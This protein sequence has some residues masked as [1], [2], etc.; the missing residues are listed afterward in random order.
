MHRMLS[1]LLWL[2]QAVALQLCWGRR[3][4]RHEAGHILLLL[5]S[6]PLNATA[7]GKEGK[8]R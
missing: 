8:E 6:K 1:D 7:Q 3:A 5:P 4:T 2:Q